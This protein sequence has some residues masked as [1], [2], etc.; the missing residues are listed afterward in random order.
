MEWMVSL[1]RFSTFYP[2]IFPCLCLCIK[3]SGILGIGPTDLTDGTVVGAGLIPTVT[4][5]LASQGTIPEKVVGVFFAPTTDES[6]TNGELT[7]GGIDG[8]LTTSDVSFV[9]IT[10][11]SP[12]SQFFGIDQSITYGSAGT[13]ILSSTAGIVDTGT[14]EVYCLCVTS[15]AEKTLSGT[16]LLLIAT[17]AFNTYKSLTGATEDQNTGLLRI[18]PENY[19]NL[20][21]L[22]FNIGG[23]TFEFTKNAQVY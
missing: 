17:D 14:W 18:S 2:P 4:D 5:N 22:L 9:P 16:T 1:C 11:T 6:I 10:S 20:Q 23:T 7:F 15:S 13:T 21:S 19:A 3:S 12:A 8:S